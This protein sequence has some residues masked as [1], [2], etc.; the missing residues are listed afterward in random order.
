MKSYWLCH[1]I[2]DYLELFILNILIVLGILI[3]SKGSIYIFIIFSLSSFSALFFIY[4]ISKYSNKIGTSQLL[5]FFIYLLFTAIPNIFDGLFNYYETLIDP[6]YTIYDIIPLTS[7][8]KACYSMTLS[9]FPEIVPADQRIFKCLL[10]QMIN[11]IIYFILFVL[12]EKNILER[13]FNYIKVKYIIKDNNF[14]LSTEQIDR[15]FLND[16]QLSIQDLPLFGNMN[17]TKS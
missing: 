7:M 10:I 6:N 11:F 13:F 2:Y 4:I 12:N 15:Q 17:M 1:F 9:Y 16:N 14:I 5:L 3:V 8:A